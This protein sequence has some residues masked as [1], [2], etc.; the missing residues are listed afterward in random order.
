MM[1][2]R[3]VV[4]AV[5]RL[6]DVEPG[7]GCWL[8]RGELSHNGYGLVVR[9]RRRVRVHRWV[10]TMAGRTI[11]DGHDLDHVCRTRC[12]ANPA[13]LTPRPHDVHGRL[14]AEQRRNLAAW[15]SSA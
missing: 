4:P 1:I 13:H 10:W 15:E 11:P 3:W 12:C 7:T 9:R 8:W 5:A 6:L 14:S 2:P